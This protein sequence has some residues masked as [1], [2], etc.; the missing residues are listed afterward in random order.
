MHSRLSTSNR[1]PRAESRGVEA[2]PGEPSRWMFFHLSFLG[3]F[4]MSK[5]IK[6]GKKFLS[7]QETGATMI[8]YGLLAALISIA[9][10]AALQLL[11]PQL[12]SIF[13]S[14]VAALTAA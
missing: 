10:L 14:I 13:N 6:V 2:C 12:L 4:T 7:R 3:G 11:G 8:E 9:A 1:D 5:L